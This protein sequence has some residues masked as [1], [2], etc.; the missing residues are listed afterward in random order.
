M[1]ALPLPL[2][3]SPCQGQGPEYLPPSW[4]LRAQTGAVERVWGPMDPFENCPLFP[5]PPS[6]SRADHSRVAG[7]DPQDL[8][9]VSL[10]SAGQHAL[11]HD[12]SLPPKPPTS[13]CYP[14]LPAGSAHSAHPLQ[15]R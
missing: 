1:S 4:D 13:A 11:R 12:S 3:L 7:W 9:S 15:A 8:A 10:P 5:G 2:F 6:V 14:R